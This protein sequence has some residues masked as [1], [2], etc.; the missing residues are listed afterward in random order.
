MSQDGAMASTKQSHSG[1]NSA[2]LDATSS[3]QQNQKQLSQ[4]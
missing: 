1:G 4:P 3:S 2:F